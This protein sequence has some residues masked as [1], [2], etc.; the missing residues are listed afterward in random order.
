M[1][2]YLLKSEETTSGD[3]RKILIHST[4]VGLSVEIWRYYERNHLGD[5][6][7]YSTYIGLIRKGSF[8]KQDESRSNERSIGFGGIPCTYISI[9]SGC[10]SIY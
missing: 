9:K 1:S 10:P 6:L 4:Y 8:R 7:K 2:N 5:C 3:T